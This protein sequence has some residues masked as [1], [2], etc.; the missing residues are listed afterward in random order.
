[1]ENKQKMKKELKL[2]KENSKLPE[3]TVKRL[4]IKQAIKNIPSENKSK[5]ILLLQYITDYDILKWND[6]GEIKYKNKILPESNIISLINHVL[7][8][9]DKNKPL[10]SNVF[11]KVL[12]KIDIP[13]YLIENE[14]ALKF[15]QTPDIKYNP[16]SWRPPGELVKKK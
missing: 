10:G 3:R 12:K 8:K 2:K 9:N 6:K 1:M 5:A 15:L 13:L 7:D 11:Y 14:D 16:N 4:K